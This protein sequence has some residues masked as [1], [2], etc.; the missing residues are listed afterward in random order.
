MTDPGRIRPERT[1]RDSCRYGARLFARKHPHVVCL[2]DANGIS[3]SLQRVW[4]RKRVCVSQQR[5]PA[6]KLDLKCK[7][8]PQANNNAP[9]ACV[10]RDTCS[11]ITCLEC[12]SRQNKSIMA[13]APQ[14]RA[15]EQ[16]RDR[17]AVGHS[18]QGALSALPGLQGGVGAWPT[19]WH[20]VQCRATCKKALGYGFLS[21]ALRECCAAL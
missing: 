10:G 3:P 16:H 9:R 14:Y 1:G 20:K 19:V 17:G 5:S 8:S 15:T 4:D 11:H 12:S 2:G 21:P 6:P 18:G 13:F 7:H